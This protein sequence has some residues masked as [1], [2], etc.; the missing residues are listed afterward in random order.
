MNIEKVNKSEIILYRN[1]E[2]KS[3]A[4]GNSVFTFSDL[5]EFVLEADVA[6]VE[7]NASL[8]FTGQTSTG[9]PERL[10]FYTARSLESTNRA[11]TTT[12]NSYEARKVH[13]TIALLLCVQLILS[14]LL[15]F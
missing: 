9:R 6:G 10:S 13:A 8:W 14:L 2:V 12:I 11:A 4:S 7:P 3:K 5:Q 1:P 15:I